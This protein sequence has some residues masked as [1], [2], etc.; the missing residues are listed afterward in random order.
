MTRHQSV[1]G[2]GSYETRSGVTRNLGELSDD[3]LRQHPAWA[4]VGG[5]EAEDLLLSPL[6]LDDQGLVPGSVG[7]VWCLCE[8]VFADGSQYLATA[9]CRGDSDCDPVLWSVSNQ[10]TWVPLF[11][12]PP[13]RFVLR[14]HGPKVFARRFGRRA[15][16]VFPLTMTV[17]PR[18]DVE[19][20]V[21]SIRLDKRGSSA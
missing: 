6:V 13:P 5:Y 16:S 21:R 2:V 12:S 11:L 17:V 8:A 19:P 20:R 10:D 14:K 4:V 18:F 7:E 1:D 9:M 15:N 3:D